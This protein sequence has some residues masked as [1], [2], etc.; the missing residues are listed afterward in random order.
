MVLDKMGIDNETI[1][2]EGFRPEIKKAKIIYFAKA[3]LTSDILLSKIGMAI[4]VLRRK[5]IKDDYS[6]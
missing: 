2:I 3:S 1:D 4:T 5:M 6:K